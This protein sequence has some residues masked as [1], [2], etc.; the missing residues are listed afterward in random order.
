[1]AFN[2]GVAFRAFQRVRAPK[3]AR[4]PTEQPGLPQSS[5]ESLPEGAR[6]E[7]RAASHRQSSPESAFSGV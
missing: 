4:P 5:L 1:M 7:A 6:P 2:G 3:R